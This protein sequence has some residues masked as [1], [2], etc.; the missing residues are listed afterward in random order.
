MSKS[1]VLFKHETHV[2]RYRRHRLRR[3][4]PSSDGGWGLAGRWEE[5]TLALPT[6]GAPML[7]PTRALQESLQSQLHEGLEINAS[8]PSAVLRGE[9][10]ETYLDWKHTA[11]AIKSE[12]RKCA[13]VPHL[14]Q[15]NVFLPHTK[16]CLTLYSVVTN[17]TNLYL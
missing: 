13:I 15:D 6:P 4:R 2:R 12:S 16:Y 3:R 11:S 14:C 9:D 17:Q 7:V 1:L 10:I 5:Q 8:L